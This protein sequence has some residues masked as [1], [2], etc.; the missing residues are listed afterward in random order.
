MTKLCKTHRR[1]VSV[2]TDGCWEYRARASTGAHAP[3]SDLPRSSPNAG[4]AFAMTNRSTGNQ[5]SFT[6]VLPTA[7]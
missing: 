1:G 3:T 2:D 4:A 6:S 5:S 7:P